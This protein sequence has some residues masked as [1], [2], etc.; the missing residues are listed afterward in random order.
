MAPSRQTLAKLVRAYSTASVPPSAIPNLLLKLAVPLV[1]NDG[2]SAETLARASL[3]LPRPHTPSKPYSRHTINNLFPSAPV[4]TSPIF[5]P[6]FTR[7]ELIA[8]ARSLHGE[9]G[10]KERIGPAKAL[11]EAWLEEGRVQM[12]DKV[13]SN[14]IWRGEVGVREGLKERLRYNLQV[15]PQLPSALGLL[16]ASTGSPLSSVAAI[17]PLP[18]PSGYLEHVAQIAQDLAKR[19][20]STF[21]LANSLLDGSDAIKSKLNDMEQFGTFVYRSWMGIGRSLGL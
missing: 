6:S 13:A 9:A 14:T 20:E 4:A 16:G 3:S 11:V 12:V 15:L 21:E 18:S 17:L 8:D 10:D 2:F 1:K 7:E 19:L 5:A